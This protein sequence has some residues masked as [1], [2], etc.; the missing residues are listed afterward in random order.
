MG[1]GRRDRHTRRGAL[2]RT[3][4]LAG[5][6]LALLGIGGSTANAALIDA[7]CIGAPDT[8]FGPFG[9]DR[10]AETFVAAHSGT[11]VQAT[12]QIDN[13]APGGNFLMQ[14]LPATTGGAPINSILGSTTIPD[15]SVPAGPTTLTANFAPPVGIIGRGSYALVLSRPGGAFNVL[16]RAGNVCPGREF[17]S[18]SQSDPWVPDDPNSDLLFTITVNPTNDFTVG[19]Q[20]GRLLHLTLPSHGSVQFSESRGAR[21]SA[22]A[23]RKRPRALKSV[24]VQAGPGGTTIHLLLTKAGKRILRDRGKLGRVGAVTFTPDGG[25]PK[26]KLVLLRFTQH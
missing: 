19:R 11:V 26:T 4:A 13:T 15:G 21:K 7:Q 12:A 16:E 23:A 18:A 20:N 25:E 6:V 3:A 17:T 10:F 2:T 14:I 1:L 9:D 24:L 22:V 5:L 8:E